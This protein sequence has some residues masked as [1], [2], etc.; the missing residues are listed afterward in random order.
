MLPARKHSCGLSKLQASC[1]CQRAEGCRLDRRPHDAAATRVQ[2]QRHHRVALFSSLVMTTSPSS[3]SPP[4]A[5]AA[6][7]AARRA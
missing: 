5:A 4:P 6:A 2:C 7:A 1:R 3:S